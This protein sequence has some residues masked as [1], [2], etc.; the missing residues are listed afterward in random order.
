VDSVRTA[1]QI[2]HL[3]D[4][5]GEKF[6]HVHVTAPYEI[7]KQRYEARGSVADTGMEY[8][9]VRADSTE[10]GVWLLDRIADRIVEN[11]NCEPHSLLA[12]AVTGLALFPSAALPQ[13]DVMV[14]G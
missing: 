11:R 10:S 9:Q 1:Q 2:K 5:H 8:D 3:R 12:K 6:V 13:V 7:I 4:E 14:G